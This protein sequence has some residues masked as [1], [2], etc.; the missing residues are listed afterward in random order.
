MEKLTKEGPEDRQSSGISI[1]TV[2]NSL[3]ETKENISIST[4]R[5]VK[6]SKKEIVNQAIK[7]HLQGNI[8]QAKKRYQYVIELGSNDP[9]V[10]SNYG[11]ILRDQGKTKESEYL[12]R[13]AIELKPDFVAP[14]S[15][16]GEM[17]ISLDRFSE[18][19]RLLRKAINLNPN[20]IQSLNNLAILLL[21][22]GEND[23]ALKYFYRCVELTR[24]N[25]SEESN[26][27]RF[28]KISKA[29]IDHDIEQFEYLASQNCV[30]KNFNEL[31][32]I[33]KRVDAEISWPSETTL[34]DLTGKYLTLLKDS[35]NRLIHKVEVTRIED[36]AVNSNLDFDRITND[37]FEH[38]FGLT[39]IDNFLTTEALESL[40][41][42]FLGSTIWFDVKGGGYLGA[43]LNEG[44]ANP[45]I[46]QIAEELR[47]KFPEILQSYPI[48]QIWAF[49]YDSRAMRETSLLG[50]TGVHADQAAVNLNFWITSNEA[51]LNPDSGGIIVY[52]VEAPK[53]WEF[54]TYNQDEKKMKAHLKKSNGNK[55]IFPHKS[56]RAVL[57]NSNLFHE[58]D[59]YEFKEGYENRRINVTMLFGNRN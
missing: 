59:T 52:E 38:E 48:K 18:A 45:L 57:F 6:P 12:L 43:Y 22:K 49:K 28:L 35:Y 26:D 55:K 11:L 51:N 19:E 42:F 30:T 3:D 24:V 1:F 50:G 10:F 21:N 7:Y 47:K 54:N 23:L 29:K 34:I 31:A 16:L 13:K 14:Y 41:K 53:E 32:T 5:Q 2:P 46:L 56:N 27:Y 39:C 8:L 20:N 36:G 15:N 58:T 40:R 25:R 4:I 33:Y 37:Y 44:L 9:I 17:L